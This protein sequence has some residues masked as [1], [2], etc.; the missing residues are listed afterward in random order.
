MQRR[1][2]KQDIVEVTTM[3]LQSLERMTGRT[4]EAMR[5]EYADKLVTVE[6]TGFKDH[7]LRGPDV[8]DVL[9]SQA[10]QKRAHAVVE[11]SY[12]PVGAVFNQDDGTMRYVQF[13]AKGYCVKD[14]TDDPHRG[15]L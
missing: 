10:R 14:V 13:F 5:D 1:Q 15:D 2:T 8:D 3:S 7:P 11:V 4:F 6:G 12:V 9:R